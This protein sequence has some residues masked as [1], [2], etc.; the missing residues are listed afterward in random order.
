VIILR[1]N[2]PDLGIL[3]EQDTTPSYELVCCDLSVG[4]VYMEPGSSTPYELKKPYHLRAGE[5]IVV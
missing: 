1:K 4:K 2:F 5:C 3:I